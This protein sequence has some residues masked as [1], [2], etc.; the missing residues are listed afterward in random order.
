MRVLEVINSLRK[1]GGS[2]T[3]SIHL[4]EYLRKIDDVYVCVLYDQNNQFLISNLKSSVLPQRLYI[5]H[6]NG[7]FD[8]SVAKAISKIIEDN[9]IDILHSE[10]DA[11]ISSYLGVRRLKNKPRIIHTLH[12][13]PS[14]ECKGYIKR[15]IYKYLFKKQIA[16]PV[17]ITEKM[18]E[19]T[20]SFYGLNNVPVIQNGVDIKQFSKIIP[21][22]QRLVDCTIIAR[23][24]DQKNYP[25]VLNVFNK[26]HQINGS[27]KFAIYGDGSKKE[28]LLSNIKDLDFISYRG[29]TES[30]HT[31]MNETKVFML[32]SRYEGNPMTL[33]EAMACGC[34]CVV[35]N[36][37]DL[38]KIVKKDTGYVLK[39][40]HSDLFAQTI[41]NILADQKKSEKLSNNAVEW[42][43]TN[44][45]D[46]V[47]AKYHSLF[48]KYAQ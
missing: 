22:D 15:I 18:A 37:N 24:E 32:G 8:I 36:I 12:N 48:Q 3:F 26:A 34:I 27:L 23:L 16:I 1:V 10:N 21:F 11:L 46:I 25:F 7:S 47:S 43:R 39:P 9:N 33:W 35:P 4:S 28:W 44:S 29:I 42:A 2:E 30:P 45:F 19:E 14:E 31:A 40:G 13:P 38:D 5:L 6:K 17:A 41:C 20:R